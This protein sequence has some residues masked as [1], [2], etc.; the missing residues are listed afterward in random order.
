MDWKHFLKVI[1]NSFLFLL[2]FDV[3]GTSFQWIWSLTILRLFFECRSTLVSVN[4]AVFLF[5]AAS[6]VKNSDLP[7]FSLP[8]LYGA[9]INDLILVGEWWRLVTP[10]FLVQDWYNSVRVSVLELFS[11][12]IHSTFS[13]NTS[14]T[15]EFYLTIKENKDRNSQLKH[16][17]IRQDTLITFFIESSENIQSFHTNSIYFFFN[18]IVVYL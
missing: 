1:P 14:R 4:I 3:E 17:S 9:K 7:L 8:S 13:N 6:P 2:M 15:E 11:R 16:S 12:F 18:G 10:M 5:E